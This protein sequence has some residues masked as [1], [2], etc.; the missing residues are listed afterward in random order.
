MDSQDICFNLTQKPIQVPNKS[1][2]I[3]IKNTIKMDINGEKNI[4]IYK[5]Q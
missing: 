1:K 4:N 3:K 2:L 5:E